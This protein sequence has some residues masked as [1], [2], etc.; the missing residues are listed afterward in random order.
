MYRETKNL[1]SFGERNFLF[2]KRYD[3]MYQWRRGIRGFEYVNLYFMIKRIKSELNQNNQLFSLISKEELEELLEELKNFIKKAKDLLI[4][5]RIA[6]QKA[7]LT[8]NYS[9]DETLSSIRNEL[10]GDKKSYGGLYKN[11]IEKVDKIIYRILKEK[12]G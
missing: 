5:E 9:E 8:F 1:I 6:L 3:F 12:L 7:K 4:K 2:F 11:L 10:F